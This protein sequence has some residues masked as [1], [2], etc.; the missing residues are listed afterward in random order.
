MAMTDISLAEALSVHTLA[1]SDSDSDII[2]FES[3]PATKAI[4][5]I[6]TPINLQKGDQ[7]IDFNVYDPN[8]APKSSPNDQDYYGISLLIVELNLEEQPDM[9]TFIPRTISKDVYAPS[10]WFS[11]LYNS[12]LVS[13]CMAGP[14]D[15]A[16]D[17]H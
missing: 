1:N 9:P 6:D 14:P 7:I 8:G 13:L 12:I 4:L 15:N 3:P 17:E 5:E 11:G 2:V 10:S 16:D